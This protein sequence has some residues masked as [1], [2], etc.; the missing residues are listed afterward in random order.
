MVG[1]YTK[2]SF[3]NFVRKV[4]FPF[5]AVLVFFF[6]GFSSS[7]AQGLLSR[8]SFNL[9][10]VPP[11]YQVVTERGTAVRRVDS[12]GVSDPKDKYADI[13]VVSGLLVPIT[14]DG[15]CLTAAH[16]IGKGDLMTIFEPVPEN[17][18]YG[19]AF[20]VTDFRENAPAPFVLLDERAGQAVTI[21]QT[22]KNRFS[23]N[24]VES[25][26]VRVLSRVL[27]ASDL[28]IAKDHLQKS[29]DLFCIKLKEVKIWNEDD[30]AL[31][32]IPFPTP[33]YFSLSISE[34]Q[35]GEPIMVFM[36]P[37]RHAGR[38][39]YVTRRIDRDL[40]NLPI[41][42][43]SFYP[44]KMAGK[45]LSRDGDSGGAIIN[46]DGELVGI[47]IGTLAQGFGVRAVEVAAGLRH[48]V[49]MEMIEKHRKSLR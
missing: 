46:G 6:A 20:V 10:E 12:L 48:T 33:S 47:K 44:L 31:V 49:I 19:A 14:P 16:N 39:N 15:Y 40:D 7:F 29:D 27:E 26:D 4:R 21:K 2:N 43:S 36:N 32:K 34:V 3:W 25:R 45:G 11:L 42:F 22:G 8:A 1:S 28:Q 13:G 17:R 18:D 41:T 38:L 9:P 5:S 30:L 23:T 35:V 37:V 24:E